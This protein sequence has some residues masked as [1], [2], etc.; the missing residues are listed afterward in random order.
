MT[1]KD[2]TKVIINVL[3]Y[4][5]H[6]NKH[7]KNHRNYKKLTP[8]DLIAV[9]TE[10]LSLSFWTRFLAKYPSLTQKRQGTVSMNRAL[11]C[12][13]E[14]AEEHL[15]EFAFELIETGIMMNAEFFFDG[16]YMQYKHSQN[17]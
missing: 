12:T 15:D 13:R 2:L 6:Q 7:C 14:M 11:N 8:N 9:E 5:A 3:K 4:R 17:F 10:N 1:K 16:V